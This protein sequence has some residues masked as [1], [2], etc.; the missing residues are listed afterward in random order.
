MPGRPL[1]FAAAAFLAMAL[2]GAGTSRAQ[3]LTDALAAAYSNNPELNVAR[4][5]L[6]DV[7]E[8]IAIARSGNRPTLT[9]L[10]SQ[11]FET[12]R[13]VSTRTVGRRGAPTQF[14]VQLVQ[15]L[16][17]GFTTR[18][19]IRSAEASV[20]AQREL[21]K[22]T[23]QDI[24]LLTAEAFFD[25]IANRQTVSLRR[26]DVSFLGQQIRAAR[27]RFEVGEGTRT[28]ISQAEARQ[29]S[30]ESLLNLAIAELEASEAT[31]TQFTGLRAATLRDNINEDKF[32]PATL[33]AALSIGQ[34]RHPSILSAEHTVDQTLFSVKVAEGA[35]LPS[36]SLTGDAAVI[37]DPATGT[38]QND[39][40][41]VRLDLSVPI[42]QGGRVSAQ[43]RQAKEQL[44]TAR[45]QVDQVR[46]SVRQNIVA[47][48]ARL[49]AGIRTIQTSRTGVFAAQLALNGVIE[50]QRV[51]QRTTLDVLDAQRELISAQITLVDAERDRDVAAFTVLSAIGNLGARTLGLRVALYDPTEHADAVRDKWFGFRT[52]DGR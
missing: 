9:G 19:S 51:G 45:I 6:R 30:A 35:F 43:V 26:D 50:E 3:T 2:A 20:R 7:D 14:S 36:L 39:S 34:N 38:Q 37:L 15:P 28:D 48:W 46:D 52:P 11:T 49:K 44:G 13:S 32:I 5:Q 1:V 4:S 10:L 16:F 41:S 25:I 8:N 23:E 17:A 12:S 29:A 18:N 21:L 22:S 40:A 31:F 24:L 47:S 33:K 42:Y 27:D